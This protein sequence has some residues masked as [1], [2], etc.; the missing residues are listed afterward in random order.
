MRYRNEQGNQAVADVILGLTAEA[1]G[2]ET[3]LAGPQ[4][5]DPP[6]KGMPR[7]VIGRL[8]IA[9]SRNVN[10]WPVASFTMP[11][12]SLA[13]PKTMGTSFNPLFSAASATSR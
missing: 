7:F 11:S 12:A 6:S 3:A 10:V 2:G 8:A 9:H 5:A 1:Y 13:R 4:Q